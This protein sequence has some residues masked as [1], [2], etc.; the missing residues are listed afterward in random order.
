[1]IEREYEYRLKAGRVQTRALLYGAGALFMAYM[2]VTNDRGLELFVIP[3]SRTNA[4]IAYWVFAAL[5]ALFAVIDMVNVERRE[6]LRQRIAL[7]TDALVVPRS[8]WTEEEERIPYDS[9]LGIKPFNGPDS[10]VVIRHKGGEFTLKLD[11]LPD[12]RAYAEIVQ[13]LASLVA[14]AKGQ[15]GNNG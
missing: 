4:T 1:M 13:N 8:P 7:T 2:A 3:L 14:V 11:M 10:V 5:A 15:G 6:R 9:I 12:E